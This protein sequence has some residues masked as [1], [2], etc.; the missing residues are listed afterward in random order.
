MPIYEYECSRC[1]HTLEVMQKVSAAALTKCPVCNKRALH[2]RVSAGAFHLKGSGWYVT[3]FKD[4]PKT[5][6]KEKKVNE[7]ATAA[8]G[9]GKEDKKTTSTEK[10]KPAKKSESTTTE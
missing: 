4:K 9:S 3:D 10:T 7:G 2:K 6:A 5:G 8:D 1:G